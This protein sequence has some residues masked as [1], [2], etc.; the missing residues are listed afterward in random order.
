[1]G[2]PGHDVRAGA[3]KLLSKYARLR[4]DP[5]NERGVALI[6]VL[7]IFIFLFVVA[8]NFSATV[9]DEGDAAH[10]FSEDTQGYYLAVAGFQRGLY[11][12]L[13]QP[14]AGAASQ[15]KE[16]Q[17]EISPGFFDGSWREDNLGS[18]ISR[19]RLIDEGGKINLNRAD[20]NML[21]RVFTNL[22]IEE[23]RRSILVD[24]ILD[25]IDPDDLH[26]E[27]GAENDYYLSLPT[28][29]TARNGPFDTV[30]DLLWVRGMTSELFF[31]SPGEGSGSAVEDRRIGLAQIFTVDSPIDRVNLRTAP[32][33][34]IHALLGIPLDKSRR[35]VEERTKL[36]EKTLADLLP[37]L[38][39]GGTDGGLQL[40]VFTNPT[41]ITVEAE[42]LPKDSRV[43]RRVKGLVRPSVGGAQIQVGQGTVRTSPGASGLELVRWIDH[44]N[45][46]PQ[47]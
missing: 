28:P 12:Y 35:F 20:E 40:F 36:S 5:F 27:N 46:P 8:F 11:E 19:V 9:R 33:E 47:N 1:M 14:P 42:G 15:Q 23:P 43:P 21:R 44:E 6:I 24:S 16:Q 45:M 7:W 34:V 32:A 18:G 4:S 22:G 38:G 29:Y 37:L 26:R 39:L 3:M 10:R 13:M 2:F 41:M 31:G 30:E 25:W 17:Q